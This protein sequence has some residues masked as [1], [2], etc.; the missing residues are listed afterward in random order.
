ML[1]L[2]CAS[3]LVATLTLAACAS[4]GHSQTDVNPYEEVQFHAPLETP[5]IAT[6]GSDIFVAGTYIKSETVHLHKEV[7]LLIPG[8]MGI[9][10]HVVLQAGPL[11]MVRIHGEWKYFCAAVEQAQA[12]FPGL[13]SVVR[14]GDCIGM[15]Q[16]MRSGQYEW[17]VDNSIYNNARTGSWIWSRKVAAEFTEF[18]KK[19][20][21][22]PFKARA[23]HRIV[24]DG[25]SGGQFRFTLEDI[26]SSQV[27]SKSFAFDRASQGATVVGIKGKV[28]RILKA[29]NTQ[30]EYVWEKL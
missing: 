3:L 13:G 7:S 16:S 19:S 29:D 28:F 27:S 4:G 22:T 9:P 18:E 2:R 11:P 15:R 14:D 17:I 20:S 5:L 24:Y 23:L 10:F 8:A 30:I 26:T 6:T 21:S 1:N 12:S 25:M